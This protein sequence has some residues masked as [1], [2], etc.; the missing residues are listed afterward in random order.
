[1]LPGVIPLS[2]GIKL[3][4]GGDYP[5]NSGQTENADDGHDQGIGQRGHHSRLMLLPR[6]SDVLD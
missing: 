6:R 1:M 5:V 4:A 3:L 2:P